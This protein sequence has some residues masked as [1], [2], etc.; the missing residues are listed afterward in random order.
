MSKPEL[1]GPTS[2]IYMSQRLR[3]HYNDWGNAD[4]PPLLL[5]HGGRDH[6]RNWD[7]V[8]QQLRHDWHIIAPDLR[9]H[10][11]SEW[12]PDGNYTMAA[13]IYDLTQLIHQLGYEKISIVAHSLGG[14]IAMRYA[15]IYPETVH[16]LV[17]VEGT[18][19]MPHRAM[20][21]LTGPVDVRFRDWIAD[22]RKLSGRMPRR[23]HSIDE[24]LARMQEE[25]SYLTNEQAR[26]LTIHAISQNEDGTWSWK[27][28]NY[29]RSLWPVDLSRDEVNALL[30]RITCPT[31][32]MWGARS[33]ATHPERDGIL[34]QLQNARVVEFEDAGHWLHH[35]QFGRFIEELRAFL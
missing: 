34:A 29:T 3:L 2:H 8:A 31:L 1:T 10:G 25:N 22:R 18:G 5:L 9:G 27:F 28:D 20:E 23:Y 21:R 7:W 33:W 14:Q 6:S 4:A 35:D 15:G 32:L 24:A 30:S 19:A 26:H 16:R 11:N 13:Y 17:S 12:S